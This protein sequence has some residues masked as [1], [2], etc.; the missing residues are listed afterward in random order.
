MI[1]ISLIVSGDDAVQNGPNKAH[2]R[3]EDR[4]FSYILFR[5]S[6]IIDHPAT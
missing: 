3:L 6:P 5:A 2:K 1:I 4:I